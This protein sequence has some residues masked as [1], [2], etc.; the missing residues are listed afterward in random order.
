MNPNY[1]DFE[2]QRS[3]IS[4]RE[5]IR[6]AM[7]AASG[8][9]LARHLVERG[10]AF[11]QAWNFG[12]WDADARPVRWIAE[13]LTSLWGPDARYRVEAPAQGAHEAGL[14]KLD[15]S[16]ART[17]LGWQP[18]WGL[19]RALEAIMEWH[20]AFRAGADP[21]ETTWRQIAAFEADAVS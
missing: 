14:L 3:R 17:R 15:I 12:P 9:V 20:R 11:A 16:K 2:K 7:F 21:R 18:R 13:R 10:P 19:G 5:A 4:R 6:R 1:S 8:L